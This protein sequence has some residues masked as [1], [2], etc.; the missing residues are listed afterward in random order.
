M[1]INM[2]ETMNNLNTI[3][4]KLKNNNITIEEQNHLIIELQ[5]AIMK[6]QQYMF[7]TNNPLQDII[8][9]FY[10]PG[11]KLHKRKYLRITTIVKYLFIKYHLDKKAILQLIATNPQFKLKKKK[12]LSV[13]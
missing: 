11:I 13:F 10:S 8:S 4:E 2:N 9:L 6:Y 3:K 7:M 12:Y 5:A 1:S